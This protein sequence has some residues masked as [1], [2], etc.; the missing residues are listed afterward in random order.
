[1]ALQRRIYSSGILLA[2]WI[3]LVGC[4]TAVD[5]VVVARVGDEEIT[6]DDLRS[7]RG[8]VPELF[9]SRETGVEKM[10]DYL[11][12]MIDMKLMLLEARESA[13]D[14]DEGFL[15]EWEKAQRERL[16][17]EF[18][19]R[20]IRQGIDIPPEELKGRY[21]ESKWSHLI[22]VARIRTDSEE[23]ATEVVRA[24]EQGTSFENVARERSSDRETAEDGGLIPY[25]VGRPNIGDLRVTMEIAEQ[26]FELNV[27]EVSEP[28]PLRAGYEIYKVVERISAPARYGEIFARETLKEE[29][30][31]R[32]EQ[33][34]LELVAEFAVQMDPKGVERLIDKAPKARGET[35]DLSAQ[36]QQMILCRFDGGQ[37]TLK[38]FADLYQQVWPVLP[39]RFDS[40]G[41]VEF[42][43]QNLLSNLL[44]HQVA[45]REGYEKDESVAT[46]LKAG[47]ELLLLNALR[48][49]EVEKRI[50]VSDEEARLYY[51]ANL[52]RFMRPGDVHVIEILT[53][54]RAEAEQY[55]LR[56]R[57]GEDIGQLASLHSLRVGARENEGRLH[58]HGYERKRYG[59]LLDSAMKTQPGESNGP[60]PVEEGYS[61]FQVVEKVDPKPQPFAEA[62]S[63]AT[64]FVKKE[65]KERL[66]QDLLSRLREKYAPQVVVFEDHLKAVADGVGQ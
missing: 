41:I 6:I 28:F 46:G 64:Y 3:R 58:M 19:E 32:R 38:D 36:E 59:T 9:R 48:E 10:R 31:T 23:A 18:L 11:R 13:L 49:R 34:L 20:D 14:R 57:G 5:E 37:L 17:A 50:A 7:F 12:T 43:T 47:K 40:T 16:V 27:G 54:S 53:G 45:L 35:I 2:G 30:F 51:D 25:Y 1:M 8:D 4:D 22:M 26:L 24:L 21:E 52:D 63:R 29:F 65:K 33:R 62:V 61:V 39:V 42:T 55:L 56:I 15:R 44:M 60:V 66:F